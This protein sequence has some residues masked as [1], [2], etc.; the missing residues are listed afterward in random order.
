[1]KK[2]MA[3]VL[4]VG[5]TLSFTACSSDDNAP[6]RVNNE[7]EGTWVTDSLF[8]QMGN[9]KGKHKFSEFPADGVEEGEQVTKEIL[10]LA[11]TS[12]TLQEFQ[13]NGNKLPEAS[14]TIEDKKTIV[15]KGSKVYE[16][17]KIIGVT[18]TKLSLE[19]KI[20]MRGAELPVTVTYIRK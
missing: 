3:L 14:G 4:F 8:Y 7:Y 20:E 10:T 5:T 17:R 1:M 15:L 18:K 13:K 19:Y 12:A 6:V 2:L 16:P 11:T 9:F